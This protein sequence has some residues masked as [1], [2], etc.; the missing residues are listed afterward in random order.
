MKIRLCIAGISGKVGKALAA[1]VVEA[2]DLELD[3][4]VSRRWAG[5][6]LGDVLEATRPVPGTVIQADLVSA[7]DASRCEVWSTTTTC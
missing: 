7:L 2:P 4:G 3:G 1:A 6:P 5:R